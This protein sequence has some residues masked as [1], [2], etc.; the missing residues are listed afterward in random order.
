MVPDYAYPA[1]IKEALAPL[2]QISAGQSWLI[3]SLATVTLV[4]SVFVLSL[5]AFSQ[6]ARGNMEIPEWIYKIQSRLSR[7]GLMNYYGLFARMTT[8]RR[9]V[10]IEGS[11]DG[12]DWEEYELYY[13][14]GDVTKRPPFVIGHLPRLDWR[15][16]FCQFT[17]F[18]SFLPGWFDIFLM[19]ILEGSPQVMELIAKNPFPEKPPRFLRAV[20]YDYNFPDKEK[21]KEGLWWVRTHKKLWWPPCTLHKGKMLY[22]K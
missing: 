14:P 4:A 22:L 11:N 16:W 12:R 6:V 20:M 5:V 2:S 15:L 13:K 18:N 19:K 9:E 3:C 1:S 7:F 21:H 8:T 17:H 10:I